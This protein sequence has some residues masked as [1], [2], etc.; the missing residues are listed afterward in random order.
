MDSTQRLYDESK[1][2]NVYHL[3]VYSVCL[4]MFKHFKGL[5]PTCFNDMFSKRYDVHS[6]NTRNANL[7]ELVFCRTETH[8]KS[9]AYSGPFIINILLNSNLIDIYSIN[10]IH[11]FR[12]MVKKHIQALFSMYQNK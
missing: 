12:K 7:Y 11:Y 6:C 10:S 4:F 8:K 2:I 5:L 1:I 3:Y 9:V